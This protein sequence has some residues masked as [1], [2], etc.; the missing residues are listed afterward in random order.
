MT[1]VAVSIYT[2][3]EGTSRLLFVMTPK[4]EK[5]VLQTF[6]AARV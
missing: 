6:G 5:N 4:D 1:P 3:I 2:S